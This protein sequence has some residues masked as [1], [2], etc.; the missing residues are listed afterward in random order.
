MWAIDKEW[1]TTQKNELADDQGALNFSKKK[2][3]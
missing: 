1:A 2:T 3:P